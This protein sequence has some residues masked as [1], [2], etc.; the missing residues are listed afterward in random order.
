MKQEMKY[1]AI[2]FVLLGTAI[3][4]WFGIDI[5]YTSF[6]SVFGQ[7]WGLASSVDVLIG[8]GC[9]AAIIFTVESDRLI[10]TL[11]AVP[12]FLLASVKPFLPVYDM[13]GTL[14]PI[15]LLANSLTLLW[16][17]LRFARRKI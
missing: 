11:W 9:A 1:V 6:E 5:I 12:I 17:I 8:A 7:V 13:D 16:V 15:L 2:I 3:G 4:G 14:A 10:A